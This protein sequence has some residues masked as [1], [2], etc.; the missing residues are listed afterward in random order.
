M[1]TDAMLRCC[2]QDALTLAQVLDNM[3]RVCL[4]V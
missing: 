4:R 3:V 1:P 2:A